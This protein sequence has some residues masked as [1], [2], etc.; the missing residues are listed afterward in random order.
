[1]KENKSCRIDQ[2]LDDE[3]NEIT[4]AFMEDE[5]KESKMKWT[6][7]IISEPEIILDRH[8][9]VAPPYVSKSNSP[10]SKRSISPILNSFDRTTKNK[11]RLA[12]IK[13]LLSQRA[14]EDNLSAE[15]SNKSASNFKVS[16]IYRTYLFD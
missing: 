2:F 11:E 8:S 12:K 10:R 4:A 3:V 6:V 7:P 5:F 1:M 9:G 15:S 16:L 14:K 13:A